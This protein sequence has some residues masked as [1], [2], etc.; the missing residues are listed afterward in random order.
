[1]TDQNKNSGLGAGQHHQRKGRP[2]RSRKAVTREQFLDAAVKLFAS[3]GVSATTLAHIAREVGVTS[4]MVHYHF[5][6]RD[7]LLD[8]VASERILP[9]LDIMWGLITPESLKDPAQVLRDTAACI[10]D[11]CLQ[12]SWLAPM[13]LADTASPN[14]ELGQRIMHLLPVNKIQQ[15]TESITAAQVRGQL[16]ARLQPQMI[17]MSMVGLVL[18]PFATLDN[19]SQVHPDADF[20][21]E[22]LRHHV[23]SSVDNLL[24]PRL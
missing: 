21:T 1:M 4:A 20:S 23:M 17:F 14:G 18:L 12:L 2:G 5:A 7:Q 13:W 24:C 22:A 15:L 3:Q 8:A 6:N 19:C 16:D 10:F 9:F 11:H